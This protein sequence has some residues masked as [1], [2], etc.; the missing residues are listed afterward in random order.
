MV[1]GFF[2]RGLGRIVR[3][4][5]ALPDGKYPGLLHDR[6]ILPV[7]SPW[8]WDSVRLPGSP[9]ISTVRPSQSDR[10]FLWYP[11][12]LGQL[13]TED[14]KM[15]EWLYLWEFSA[16]C[17]GGCHDQA[18]E[19]RRYLM[20]LEAAAAR[21]S[22]LPRSL[23]TLLTPYLVSPVQ[24]HFSRKKTAKDRRY[25]KAVTRRN[26]V[27]SCWIWIFLRS[28]QGASYAREEENGRS[29]PEE[30]DDAILQDGRKEEYGAHF[31][32]TR[33]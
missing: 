4:F 11:P 20:T 15:S 13:S 9:L 21:H 14:W 5:R 17:R 24:V 10:A 28:V 7:R 27:F 3:W 18:W 6:E 12:L 33:S 2:Q 19:L 22:R 29:G 26:S 25:E 32:S 31:V 16:G 23:N 1:R 30:N 8:A